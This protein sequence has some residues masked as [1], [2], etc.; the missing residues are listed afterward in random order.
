MR[1]L[2]T[3][4]AGLLGRAVVP[5]LRERGHAVAEADVPPYDLRRPEAAYVA[6]HGAHSG[7]ECVIDAVVHLAGRRA[8]VAKQHAL[9][10]DLLLDNLAIDVNVLRAMR[11]HGVKRGVYAS[12]VSVYGG[13]CVD[14][15]YREQDADWF[16]D[17]SVRFSAWGKLTAE[18]AIE[19]MN[20]QDGANI[21]VV[22]LVNT[23]GP[24]DN[25]GDD[26]L[27]IPS[28]IRKAAQGDVGVVGADNERDF[29]YVDDAACGIVEALQSPAAGTWNLGT[30]TGVRIGDV[31]RLVVDA[32]GPVQHFDTVHGAQSGTGAQRKVVDPSKAKRDL[33]WEATT[34][35]AEGIRRTVEWYRANNNKAAP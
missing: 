30:G 32:W 31:A 34:P 16:P 23:Y 33:G 14:D 25:F 20:L 10:A 15:G 9:A 18:R 6:V 26:A 24:G 22:R 28:L 13:E 19:A 35:L 27:V 12:T 8:S 1:V 7:S 2:V 21:S 4:A 29:L 17:D 5:L 3:G 11:V